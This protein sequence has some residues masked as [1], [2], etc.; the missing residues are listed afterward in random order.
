M[1]KYITKQSQNGSKTNIEIE[2]IFFFETEIEYIL[3]FTWNAHTRQSGL[4]MPD[5]LVLAFCVRGYLGCE[6]MLS[7]FFGGKA[8]MTKK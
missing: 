4:H 1:P 2:Y 7:V 8:Y 6:H 3:D 5:S